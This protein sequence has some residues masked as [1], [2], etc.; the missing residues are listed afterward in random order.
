MAGLRFLWVSLIVVAPSTVARV[1]LAESKVRLTYRA[2]EECPVEG[3]FVAAIQARGGRFDDGG[4]DLPRAIEIDIRPAESGFEGSLRVDGGSGLS[5]MRR[6]HA[7][8]CAEIIEGL[9]VV[10]AIALG[11]DGAHA[12]QEVAR[13][14]SNAVPP[15]A[16]S[17]PK[18]RLQG[19]SLP[20]V[21]TVH[22]TEGMLR[23]ERETN[24][25]LSAGVALGLVPGVALPRYEFVIESA[26]F[27][28]T[29]A[30]S[31]P[32]VGPIL[33]VTWSWLGPGTYHAGDLAT[34]AFGFHTGL[35]SCSAITYD[36]QGLTFL[37]CGEFA[38]GWMK[39]DTTD[40]AGKTVQSKEVGF[41]M[42]AL[43][44]DARYGLGAHFHVGVKAGA[45]FQLGGISAERP[46][47]TEIF[48]AS[49]FGGYALAGIGL[50]F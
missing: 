44:I 22:V 36:T 50:H 16:P 32:L 28:T 33:G 13:P 19:S 3:A 48:K 39:L 41:G 12:R 2:P 23:F 35:R 46:D 34:R 14:Q 29:P 42:A 30:S 45:H 49:L 4:K 20:R 15:L 31:T 11:G 7:E 21:D 25:T 40:A 27:V 8:H 6:V 5:D 47:G 9:A 43:G 38:V 24:L 10:A 18:A 37:A 17:Q 1:A 26:H